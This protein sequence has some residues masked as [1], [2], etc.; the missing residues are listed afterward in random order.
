MSHVGENFRKADQPTYKTIESLNK[1]IS[2]GWSSAKTNDQSD[3]NFNNSLFSATLSFT[4]EGII[5][6]MAE[7]V[8]YD[9]IKKS[10]ACNTISKDFRIK[11][12]TEY[13]QNLFLIITGDRVINEY[14]SN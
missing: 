5:L 7:K 6:K 11:I 12:F 9:M 4:E 3:P 10:S 8:I 1:I 14:V 2:D 13:Y